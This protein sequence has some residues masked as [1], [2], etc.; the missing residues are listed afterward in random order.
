M[1]TLTGFQN[2][3]LVAAL[4]AA[5]PL[6]AQSLP[7]KTGINSAIGV[8]PSSQDFVK[9]V[10]ISDMYE[11]EAAKLAQQRADQAS[12]TFAT[13]MLADHMATTNELKAIATKANITV[14]TQLDSA[15]QSKLDTL[16]NLQDQAFDREYDKQQIDAHRDAVDVFQRYAEKG[17]NPDLKAFAAKYLP[18]LKD[19][20][21]QA[22]ALAPK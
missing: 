14:P 11:M 13:R 10:A 16:K 8:A 6:F 15:H 19:H 18:K 20:L 3:V 12:Q 9:I 21:T 1:R 4:T 22:E 5:T 7:E 17:D 2:V